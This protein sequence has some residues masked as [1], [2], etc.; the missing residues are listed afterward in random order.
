MLFA[1]LWAF[2]VISHICSVGDKLL[3]ITTPRSTISSRMNIL[4]RTHITTTC[5]TLQQWVALVVIVVFSSKPTSQMSVDGHCSVIRHYRLKCKETNRPRSNSWSVT[6]CYSCIMSVGL[7]WYAEL[8]YSVKLPDNCLIEWLSHNAL[9]GRW[10]RHFSE[11][12]LQ[13]NIILECVKLILCLFSDTVLFCNK[14]LCMHCIMSMYCH[15]VADLLW[16]MFFL[17]QNAFNGLTLSK[18]AGGA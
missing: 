4:Q 16:N 7:V 13:P 14:H 9:R 12:K 17:L 6:Y 10:F 3:V 1:R 8:A 18:P 15:S 5:R 2:I 11:Q